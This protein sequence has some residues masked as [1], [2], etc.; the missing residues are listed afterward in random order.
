M[1]SRNTPKPVDRKS[2]SNRSKRS[3]SRS[4]SNERINSSNRD[5]SNTNRKHSEREIDGRHQDRK[6]TRDSSNYK[7]DRLDSKVRS[8]R[9]YSNMGSRPTQASSGPLMFWGSE[10]AE[11]KATPM[12]PPKS[13]QQDKTDRIKDIN[14]SLKDD[15][16]HLYEEYGA[17]EWEEMTKDI[18]REW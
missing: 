12:P 9:G 17:Y 2:S 15:E 6:S 18:D 16:P 7:N 10:G 4:R 13:K 14:K 8:N 3:R 11:L 5:R 1:S